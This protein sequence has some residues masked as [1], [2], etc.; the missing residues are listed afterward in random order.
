MSNAIQNTSTTARISTS[1]TKTCDIWEF[2]YK[3][4]ITTGAIVRY[5]IVL[6]DN[7]DPGSASADGYYVYIRDDASYP[8]RVEFRRL[9][10]GSPASLITCTNC[11]SA[12]SVHTIKIT[13]NNNQFEL[14]FDGVSKGTATDATYAT[15]QYQG[16]WI[17]SQ[18][19]SDNHSIDN[20]KYH[21]YTCTAP[22]LDAKANGQDATTVCPGDNVQ[23]TAN[24]SGGS[25]CGSPEEWQFAWFTGDGT[26]NTYYDGTDW[27]NAI[28]AP[29]VYSAAYATVNINA[30][31]TTTY[32][33]KV[34]CSDNGCSQTD[35]TGVTVTVGG[36]GCTYYVA[37]TGSDATGNGTSGNPYAT[38]GYA[39]SQAG[40]SD[41]IQVAYGIYN[42]TSQIEI[43]KTVTIKSATGYNDGSANSV[44]IDCGDGETNNIRAFNIIESCTLKGLTIRDGRKYVGAGGGQNVG[45]GAIRFT[46]AGKTLTIENCRIINCTA[47]NDDDDYNAW[48]GAIY[49][50]DGVLNITNTIFSGNSIKHGQAYSYEPGNPKDECLGGA[51]FIAS[52][53]DGGS[54]INCTF[55]NNVSSSTDP[56]DTREEGG[57]I[58]MSSVAGAVT[59]KNCI[60]WNNSANDYQNDLYHADAGALVTYCDITE[61][62]EAGNNWIK[63]VGCLQA[64]D[65][66][67]AVDPLFTDV[68]NSDFSLQPASPCINSATSAGAPVTDILGIA[69]P[70]GAAMDMGVYEKIISALIADAGEDKIIIY[71]ESTQIGGNP[72]ATGGIPPYSYNWSPAEG[73]DAPNS[74]NPIAS[75]V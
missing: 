2:Q 54:I 36:A 13:R 21:E 14:F 27:D 4:E 64:G 37:T 68:V 72:T 6:L 39:V 60:F 42:I 70:Q 20:I 18:Y 41:I 44:V 61:E 16:I 45:G 29:G 17:N 47:Y 51:I 19:S 50:Y 66:T 46:T 48:G 73:L 33:V 23:L 71:N 52:T 75:P 59:I 53:A 9:D 69:R 74:P 26:G 28:T 10:N 5:F 58:W 22:A 40:N 1:F 56:S 43:N 25:G 8:D 57:A 38:I 65:N 63:G 31:L 32:K 35:A 7:S 67:S 55:Y 62:N 11:N 30:T 34:K 49:W 15:C 24:S 12:T 3:L